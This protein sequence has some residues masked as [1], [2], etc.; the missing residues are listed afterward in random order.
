MSRDK[1]KYVQ[2]MWRRVVI[3]LAVSTSVAAVYVLVSLA[4][5]CLGDPSCIHDDL[6][7]FCLLLVVFSVPF[8]AFLRLI[9]STVIS[10]VS[11]PSK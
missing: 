5:L 1:V 9:R 3:P 7:K 10:A 11:K 4:M 2:K 8:Y 6:F